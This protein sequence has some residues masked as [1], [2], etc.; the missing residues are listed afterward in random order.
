MGGLLKFVTVDPS[1]AGASRRVE[2]GTS[3]IENGSGVGYKRAGAVNV[4]MSDTFA[5]A[6]ERIHA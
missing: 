6:H 1:T 3:Y 4:P 5:C 2:A